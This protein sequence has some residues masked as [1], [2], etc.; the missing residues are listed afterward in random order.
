MSLDFQPQ[1][2]HSVVCNSLWSHRLQHARPPCP[3]PTPRVYSNSC[4]LFVMPSNHLILCHPLLLLP[5][6][7]PSIK[8][9]SNESVGQ[10]V[11]VS[12]SVSVHQWM[13]WTY[14]LNNGLA[15]SP[16]RPMDS[17]IFSNTTVRKHRFFG[18]QLS[19]L[20]NS[21]IHTWLPEKTQLSLH[22]PLLTK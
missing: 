11:G 21:H 6:I 20:S 10:S 5:A 1:F 3:S 12:A 22:G 8:V 4:P 15:G 16:C 18:A 9:F 14:F 13:F 2:S 17:R 19:L 7:V